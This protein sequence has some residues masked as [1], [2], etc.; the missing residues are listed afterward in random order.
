[1]HVRH[2]GIDGPDKEWHFSGISCKE[3]RRVIYKSMAFLII[4][5]DM[6]ADL[7]GV[8]RGDEGV[9]VHDGDEDFVQVDPI[10]EEDWGHMSRAPVNIAILA[11]GLP[12]SQL[13]QG[14]RHHLEIF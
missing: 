8:E 4:V 13:V 3:L 11:L 6:L 14:V 9:R 5:L 2:H 10:L 12:W 1:M 7:V